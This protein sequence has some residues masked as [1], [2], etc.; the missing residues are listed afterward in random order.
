MSHTRANAHLRAT[1]ITH[2]ER[3][4]APFSYGFVEFFFSKY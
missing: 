2:A 3:P 4:C 1:C